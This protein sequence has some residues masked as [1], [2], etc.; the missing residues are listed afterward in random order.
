MCGLF[1]LFGT[2]I[3]VRFFRFLPLNRRGAY[4]SIYNRNRKKTILNE[5]TLKY[6]IIAI[7]YN[8]YFSQISGVHFQDHETLIKVCKTGVL[9]IKLFQCLRLPTG[10]LCKLHVF[11]FHNFP[12][13]Q[14]VPIIFQDCCN[15]SYKL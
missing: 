7:I 8:F 11:Q 15:D 9:Q 4:I 3:F 1:C 12:H 13:W 2:Y 5:Y 10:V 6:A 14:K